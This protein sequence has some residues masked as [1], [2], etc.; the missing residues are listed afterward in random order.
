MKQIT[1]LI[2]QELIRKIDEIACYFKQS[3]NF[4]IREAI[5]TYINRYL[6]ENIK[7][8]LSGMDKIAHP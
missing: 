6:S 3:R 8:T 4:I 2:D 1:I 5:I 7:E